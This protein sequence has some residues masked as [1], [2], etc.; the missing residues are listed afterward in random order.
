MKRRIVSSVLLALAVW[1][2]AHH[3]L[4]RHQG[5]DPWKLFGW[6]MYSVPG[7]MKTVRVIEISRDGSARAVS[8]REQGEEVWRA[9]SRFRVLRQS[10]GRLA[11][12]EATARRV[13]ALRPDWEGV[14]LPVLGLELDRATATTR[15][16]LEQASFWRDGSPA[17]FEVTI[18]EFEKPLDAATRG[19]AR[20]PGRPDRNPRTE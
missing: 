11:G 3:A 10:L 7:A 8:R 9:V 19:P 15:A 12:A 6:A 13:L 1:P 2:L 16:S 17:G 5:V 18:A 4:V 14:A 20:G